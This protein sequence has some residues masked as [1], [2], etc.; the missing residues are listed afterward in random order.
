MISSDITQIQKT[1]KVKSSGIRSK[2][3]KI[4]WAIAIIASI[5]TVS[6]SQNIQGYFAGSILVIIAS[7]FHI[8]AKY[9]DSSLLTVDLVITLSIGYFLAFFTFILIP[10]DTALSI[11][12]QNLFKD[13]PQSKEI[14]DL[15]QINNSNYLYD[16]TYYKIWYVVY[17]VM[18]A[19]N[20]FIMNVQN[21]FHK[22]GHVFFC[23]RIVG[24]IVSYIKLCLVFVIPFVI[25]CIILF[26]FTKSFG[27]GVMTQVFLLLSNIYGITVLVLLIGY[28][29]VQF[30]YSLWSKT[31]T[32]N[33]LDV[34]L[35]KAEPLFNR[36]CDA[37]TNLLLATQK[38]Q[39]IINK[40]YDGHQLYPYKDMFINELPN[41]D[42]HRSYKTSSA[43][44]NLMKHLTDMPDIITENYL[45]NARFSLKSAKYNFIK[46][47]NKWKQHCDKIYKVIDIKSL[48]NKKDLISPTREDK[49]SKSNNNQNKDSLKS[50]FLNTSFNDLLKDYK[51]LEAKKMDKKYVIF[52]K[53]SACLAGMLSILI[54]YSETALIFSTDD[55]QAIVFMRIIQN[56]TNVAGVIV[57]I[58]VILC[59]VIHCACFALF[60]IDLGAGFEIYPYHTH[61]LTVMF[62][63]KT[64]GTIAFPL[65][66]NVMLILNQVDNSDLKVHSGFDTFFR[67]MQSV[68][69]LGR[70][71]NLIVC[72]LISVVGII[73]MFSSLKKLVKTITRDKIDMGSNEVEVEKI[74]SGEKWVINEWQ[75]RKKQ[76]FINNLQNK[77][78]NQDLSQNELEQSQSGLLNKIK[79]FFTFK[80]KDRKND[81]VQELTETQNN[82]QK[83]PVSKLAQLMNN[84]QNQS[85]NNFNN[86]NKLEEGGIVARV[87]QQQYLQQQL[88]EMSL[89]EMVNGKQVINYTNEISLDDSFFQTK[90]DTTDQDK[91]KVPTFQVIHIEDQGQDIEN[92]Q[93]QNTML[94]TN[95]ASDFY[96]NKKQQ[97]DSIARTDTSNYDLTY[98][99]SSSSVRVKKN[100]VSISNQNETNP[101]SARSDDSYAHDFE[102]NIYGKNVKHKMFNQPNRKITENLDE[103]ELNEQTEPR[104][105]ANNPQL[106][107]T[108]LNEISSEYAESQL[109]QS[110]FQNTLQQF[111]IEKPNIASYQMS[112]NVFSP[113][114]QAPVISE[115][116]NDEIQE[117]YQNHHQYEQEYNNDQFYNNNNQYIEN[118]IDQ[119]TFQCKDQNGIDEIQQQD[120]NDDDFQQNDN[121]IVQNRQSNL[122]NVSQKSLKINL[123]SIKGSVD[124]DQSNYKNMNIIGEIEFQKERKKNLK[125]KKIHKK[126]LQQGKDI[127]ENF[128]VNSDVYDDDEDETNSDQE[129]NGQQ[130]ENQEENNKSPLK[131][132]SQNIN[133]KS[134]VKTKSIEKSKSLKDDA[135]YSS[136][137]T[138]DLEYQM[139]R[140][141]SKIVQTQQSKSQINIDGGWV[142]KKSENK[143][144][145]KL[146]GWKKKY[147]I[148][149]E[150]SLF[151]YENNDQQQKGNEIQMQNIVNVIQYSKDARKANKKETNEDRNLRFIIYTKDRKFDFKTENEQDT[152][153]WVDHI[154]NHVLRYLKSQ[155]K[156][157]K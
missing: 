77:N 63:S 12:Y 18:M 90:D 157:K 140:G 149:K 70:W 99:E 54:I 105:R 93:H 15:S 83:K 88:K 22:T 132:I 48:E 11:R 129:E 55:N 119:N 53:I 30:P 46:V 36:Y 19:L 135:D 101:N 120:I 113:E 89:E 45:A 121:Q 35:T 62:N 28:G 148:V 86:S 44:S 49:H 38:M 25:G 82:Q 96:A 111:D 91:S 123:D 81:N 72:F 17:W 78:N 2:L 41:L 14:A 57:F 109:G 143:V 85:Q 10:A 8:L 98:S 59:Y 87:R 115:L 52:Y 151:Y 108:Q 142:Y 16:N 147:L 103:N 136:D 3:R 50:K 65:C 68:P 21:L 33:T 95:I 7:I 97:K 42:E 84:N 6:I 153:E 130:N 13:S 134:E 122:S 128:E 24:T 106:F 75:R 80:K 61:P 9:I 29:L 141:R 47:F 23:S 34:L 94:A 20:M 64:C 156:Q 69:F 40:I 118:Q 74:Q 116:N 110:E 107:K 31:N 58:L 100:A 5:L 138:D 124:D 39:N 127:S 114:F 104:L 139:T 146:N 32:N 112:L 92:R 51:Q 126:I 79:G 73:S 102:V 125:I 66:Y 145:R 56:S 133:Y 27:I 1:K 131:Q 137:N 60:E 26:I 67:P 152:V 76:Q 43:S 4:I 71:Y 150:G 117:E 144:M 37:Q 154:Q 155:E